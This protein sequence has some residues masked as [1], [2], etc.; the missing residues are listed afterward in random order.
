MRRPG[1]IAP[2]LAWRAFLLAALASSALAAGP[3]SKS[4]RPPPNFV[5]LGQPDQ[6]EGAKILAAFRGIGIAGEYYLEFALEVRPRRGDEQV[7]QGQM[8]GGRNA[9][10]PISRV[11]L[12]GADGTVHRL[13]IQNGP[14]PQVWSWSQGQARVAP[15]GLDRL[16]APLLPETD[17]TLFDLEMPYLYWKDFVFEGVSKVRGRAAHT[18]LLYPPDDIA[19]AYPELRGVRVQLD[20]QYHALVDAEL[21]DAD[22]HGYKSL[23]LLDLK[24]VGDQW[25]VKT[26]DLR[27]EATRN[28]TRFQVTKA[29]LNL[30]LAPTVFTPAAL[31]D[32][33][34]P[35]SGLIS[36]GP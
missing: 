31:D 2:A 22:N 10:G 1:H 30:D 5:Q 29:A 21:I 24:K 17:L 12:H 23:S 15:A 27:N 6:A 7:F 14:T 4:N 16:F 25:M 36:L 33:I 26:I 8:W 35:P 20:T 3:A 19:A 11:V 34:A 28:K 9:T 13:L 32:T 18:F